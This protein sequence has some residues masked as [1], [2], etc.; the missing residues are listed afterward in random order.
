MPTMR[1]AGGLRRSHRRLRLTIAALAAM[2]AGFAAALP[3]ASASD[4]GVL[5]DAAI[6]PH[7]VTGGEPA[8]GTVT[9]VGPVDTDTVVTLESTDTSVL[10]VPATVTVPAGAG[11]ATFTVT[12]LAFHGPGE[13]A[14]VYATAGGVTAIPCLNSNP[15]PSGPV[16]TAVTFTPATVGGGSPVT[17]KVR[18]SAAADSDTGLIHLVSSDPAVLA[19]PE[20][21]LAT[22]GSG[23]TPFPVTTSAVS[24]TRIV[25]VTAT[26]DGGS[27]SGTLTITPATAPPTTDTV[28][29]TKAEWKKGLL[30]VSATG[31]NPD[32]ILSVH[33][34][35]SDSLMFP[36]ANKGGGTYEA[37]HQWLDNP[38]SITVRSSLGGSDT[39]ST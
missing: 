1:N 27:A 29:I 14:C 4:A 21:V 38:R 7:T 18:L 36:L 12:T 37:Q 30:K 2:V 11:S 3:A 16:A 35:A 28:T 33:L 23:T 25:T 15:A 6:S 39:A 5:A 9:L 13:F 34:T 10:T 32:A 22:T 19:V 24:T 26:A 31:S 8:T 17:G 20:S